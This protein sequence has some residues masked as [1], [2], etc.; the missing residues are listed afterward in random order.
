MQ[1]QQF[2]HWLS[3]K[4]GGLTFLRLLLD[5]GVDPDNLGGSG[6]GGSTGATDN[7][8]L[9]ADGVGGATVQNSPVTIS[10]VGTI[11]GVQQFQLTSTISFPDN[12][13]QTFN[14]GTTNAGLNVG[15]TAAGDPSGPTNGDVWYDSAGLGLRARI[16]NQTHGIHGTIS[17]VFTPQAVVALKPFAYADLPAGIAGMIAYVTDSD[18][19]TPGAEVSGGDA[20]KVLA[21]YN[22]SAWTVFG[23]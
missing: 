22:G 21:F 11:S 5:A 8:V 9:R 19:N 6:I 20:F 23:S 4:F 2:K 16:A 7:R 15:D 18:T 12:I 17:D 1:I 14:P 10:D 3:Q 13:R